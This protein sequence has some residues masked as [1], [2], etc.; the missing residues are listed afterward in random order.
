MDDI[1]AAVLQC[2]SRDISI[3]RIYNLADN[4]NVTW[5]QWYDALADGLNLRRARFSVPRRLAVLIAWLFETLWWLLRLRSRPLLTLFVLNLIS[6]DQ[7]Y[8]TQ[9]AKQDLDWT[10]RVPFNEGMRETLQ[11]LKEHRELWQE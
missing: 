10:P 4:F 2:V 7:L 6:R 3:G 5:R 8:P 11:W 9:R 1:V